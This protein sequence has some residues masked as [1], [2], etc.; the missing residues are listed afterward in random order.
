[1]RAILRTMASF[2]LHTPMIHSVRRLSAPGTFPVFAPGDGVQFQVAGGLVRGR[3]SG[4]DV[5]ARRDL[6]LGTPYRLG[7]IAAPPQSGYSAGTECTIRAACLELDPT[8]PRYAESLAAASTVTMAPVR[9]LALAPARPSAPTF[10]VAFMREGGNYPI[11]GA[12]LVQG[13]TLDAANAAATTYLNDEL[14]TD[15]A[16]GRELPDAMVML[17]NASEVPTAAADV[18][19]VASV[20]W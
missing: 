2:V 6:P 19:V 18:A 9:A 7:V 5:Q 12:L 3:V 14:A 15:V 1:M 20:S 8:A 16:E 10:L 17:L 4:I 11:Q 13:E